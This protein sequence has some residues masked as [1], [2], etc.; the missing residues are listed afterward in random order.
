MATRKSYSED[1]KSTTLAFLEANRG[2]VRATA[3]QTGISRNTIQ[4][5]ATGGG[6][7]AQVAEVSAIKKGNL[8]ALWEAEAQAALKQATLIR[9]SGDTTYRD[10]ITAAAIAT[11]KARLL[12]GSITLDEAQE[13]MAEI[14][15]SVERNVTDSEALRKIASDIRGAARRVG[16]A[17]GK[18]GRGA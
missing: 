13:L 18:P 12:R 15:A 2:N 14:L 11:D 7:N 17:S 5:W 6:I 16:G 10:V 3:R 4:Y 1:D 9:Q 8:A